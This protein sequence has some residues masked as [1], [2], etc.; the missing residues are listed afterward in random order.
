MMAART[1][2]SQSKEPKELLDSGEINHIKGIGEA[3][4]DK[5]KQLV[6]TGRLDY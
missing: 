4:A 1:I 5:I 6:E 3:L 2:L